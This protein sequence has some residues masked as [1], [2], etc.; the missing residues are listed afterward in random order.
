MKIVVHGVEEAA[1]ALAY[2]SCAGDGGQGEAAN[3]PERRAAK[4]AECEKFTTLAACS[5]RTHAK[6][7]NE[8]G[9]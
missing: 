8:G 7:L 9:S 5:E 1:V 3:Y 6:R 4:A 2:G